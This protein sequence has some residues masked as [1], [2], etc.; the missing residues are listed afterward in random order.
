MNEA[1]DKKKKNNKARK[2]EDLGFLFDDELF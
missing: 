1:K 2:R